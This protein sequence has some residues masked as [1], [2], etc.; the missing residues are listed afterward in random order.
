VTPHLADWRRGGNGRGRGGAGK[1]AAKTGAA[2]ETGRASGPRIT[3][4]PTLFDFIVSA[5]FNSPARVFR[6]S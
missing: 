3:L 6:V 5:A 1:I 2:A 4:P